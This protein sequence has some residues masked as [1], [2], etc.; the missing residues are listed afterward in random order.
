MFARAAVALLLLCAPLALAR[1]RAVLIYPRERSLFRRIFYT[2]HQREL[3]GRI[4]ARY[5]IDV[6]AQVATAEELFATSVD[7]ARL[8]VISGHGGPFFISMTGR[9]TRTLDWRDRSRLTRFF[10][11]LA[12]DATIVLQSCD[13]G[14]GFAHVVKDAAGPARRVI[15]ARGEIPWDG[16]IITSVEP[17]DATIECSDG[18]HRWD[19]TVRL[20]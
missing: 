16:L 10:D 20:R 1:D 15:A 4:A 6:R 12:P 9:E 19:C 14:R 3:Q 5:D 17:F 7:G 18:R 11:R 13:T 8:L 2:R